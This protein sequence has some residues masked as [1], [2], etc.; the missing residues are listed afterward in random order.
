[1]RLVFS[2]IAAAALGACTVETAETPASKPAPAPTTTTKAGSP[3]KVSSRTA[4]ANFK[5]VVRQVEPVAEQE[6]RARAP[7]LNC[8]FKIVV[9]ERTNQPPNAFQTLDKSGRPILG[10]TIA[11]IADARNRDEVAFVMGHEAAHHIS[12]HL[13]KQQQTAM[14]GAIIGGI[15]AASVGLDVNAGQQL[16]GT[17]GARAYS[18]NNELE[19][20]ALGTV[21]AK[22][23]GY[24]PVRGAEFFTRIPDPG[25][26]FLGTHP[27]NASR[28]E[29]VRKVNSQL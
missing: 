10:F 24:D 17:V 2:F 28:I 18:K 3:P 6:C 19:A 13:A 25:D 26:R 20:D 8:D 12:K 15:I 27:P 4:V 21:I 22:R 14:G 7:D 23:A 11:L 9:D 5:A 1:M 16:G 29:T